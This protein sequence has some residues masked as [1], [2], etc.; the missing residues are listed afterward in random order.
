MPDGAACRSAEHRVVACD[1]SGNTADR[2][3][4][5]ASGSFCLSEGQCCEWCDGEDKKRRFQG[6]S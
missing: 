1:M 5:Q 6:R 2:G 3:S 4:F